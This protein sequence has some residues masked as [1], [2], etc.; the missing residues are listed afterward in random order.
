MGPMEIKTVGIAGAGAL[1]ILFGEF[2]LRALP[3]EQLCFL[4]DEERAA[5][6]TRDGLFCNGRRLP[7]RFSTAQQARPLD[8]IVF[9]VKAHALQEAIAL[10]NPFVGPQ[11]TLISLLNGV[12]SEEKIGQALGAERV[13]YTIAQ[14]M[15][16]TREGNHLTFQMPGELRVGYPPEEPE[17]AARL[18]ALTDFLDRIAF[19]YTVE[20][21]IRTRLWGKL[22]MNV[23]VNQCCMVYD[24]DYSGVQQPGS[25]RDTLLA[26]MEE[27]RQVAAALGVTLS[28]QLLQDYVALM[29][30]LTPTGM[31]S[32]QQDAL[33]G[34]PTEVDLFA[35]TILD[36]GG[37][38]GIATPVNAWLYEQIQARE[39]K[40]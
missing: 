40:Y 13:L 20:E 36:Y 38:Y 6:Y 34:R 22:M 2:C 19:P 7:A 31:P 14:G 11:T 10:A 25:A 1:G 27:T 9:A 23:G 26:A 33:A 30:T 3:A 15:D 28:T 35:G 8:L 32:M 17:K 37:R 21:D 29:D 12:T 24:C 16:A 4:V 39:A 5:R 18:T